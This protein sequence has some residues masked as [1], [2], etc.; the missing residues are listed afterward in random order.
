MAYRGCWMSFAWSQEARLAAAAVREKEIEERGALKAREAARARG[1]PAPEDFNDAPPTV[2]DKLLS[3][4]PYTLP[5]MDS[6]VFGGHIFQTFPS[7][8]C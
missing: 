4:L 7:Q 1:L 6:L 5:L 3:A 2:T 8:V